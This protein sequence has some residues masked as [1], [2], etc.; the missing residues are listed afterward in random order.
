V[1]NCA[2]DEISSPMWIDLS[3]DIR[4]LHFFE[5]FAESL[6]ILQLMKPDLFGKLNESTTAPTHHNAN[7]QKWITINGAAVPVD[8]EGNLQG[9]VGNNIME[10]DNNAAQ[11]GQTKSNATFG[12][13]FES[14]SAAEHLARRQEEGH[15]TS[16]NVEQYEAQALELLQKEVDGDIA[17]YEL[18]NGKVVRWNKTTN[19]YATGFNGRCIKTMFPFRGEQERFDRLRIRDEKEAAK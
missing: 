17:G 9:E 18:S 16:L 11:M 5:P 8:G 7:A 2:S 19:D 3:A 1:P 13:G 12:R 4:G 15:Y 6:K 14:D 10:D